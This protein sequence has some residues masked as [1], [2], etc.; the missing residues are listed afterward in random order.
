[1]AVQ[2][3]DHGRKQAVHGALGDLVELRLQLAAFGQPQ[4][5]TGTE[6]RPAGVRAQPQH[7]ERV[8]VAVQHR[9]QK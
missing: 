5:E 7:V 3:V 9:R 8:R 6:R 2:S 4:A 1:M